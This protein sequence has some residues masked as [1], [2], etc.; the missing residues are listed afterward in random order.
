[1]RAAETG[2]PG[3]GETEVSTR[4]DLLEVYRIVELKDRIKFYGE[5]V[6]DLT[7]SD[8]DTPNRELLYVEAN[9]WGVGVSRWSYALNRWVNTHLYDDSGAIGTSEY[10]GYTPPFNAD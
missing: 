10:S 5:S 1:M 4:D 6:S 9:Q 7:Q 3:L 2:S 8:Y